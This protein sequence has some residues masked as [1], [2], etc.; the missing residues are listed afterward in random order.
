MAR[1]GGNITGFTLVPFGISGKRL[2]LMR[3]ALPGISGVTVLLNP[4]NASTAER[5]RETQ[6]AAQTLGLS[7]T[8]IAAENVDAL[9]ALRPSAFDPAVP[10]VVLS[11]GM[12][13]EYRADIVALFTAARVP[14]LYPQREYAE[15]GG[16][17]AYGPNVADN[18]RKTA[19][20]VDRILKGAMPGDLPVQEPARFDFVVNL[21]AARL[22]GI[23]LS[24]YFISSA[25]EVIQ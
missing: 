18:F 14:V 7:V 19:E 15:I 5:W 17:I 21:R 16:L 22:L 4:A 6:T 23:S 12:F 8:P 3:S 9:R 11:D 2:D 25:N 24:P 20:Y 1:P 10:V 13:S